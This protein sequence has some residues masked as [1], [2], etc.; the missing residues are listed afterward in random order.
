MY[1]ARVF[2]LIFK[3][4]TN[5]GQGYVRLNCVW[6]HGAKDSL[7]CEETIYSSEGRLI[8]GVGGG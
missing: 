8:T 6:T 3:P 1:R 2:S 4:P 7:M 5:F